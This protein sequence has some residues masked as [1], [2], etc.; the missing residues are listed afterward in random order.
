MIKFNN[1]TQQFHYDS[2]WRLIFTE[3][4]YGGIWFLAMAAN[5]LLTMY[6]LVF[7]RIVC[8]SRGIQLGTRISFNRTYT[9]SLFLEWRPAQ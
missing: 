6:I 1:L 5:N 9:L 4:I 2:D 3:K 8:E 7:C